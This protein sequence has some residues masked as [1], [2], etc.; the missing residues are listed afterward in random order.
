MFT[1][2][3]LNN[4]RMVM[5]MCNHAVRKP[6]LLDTEGLDSYDGLTPRLRVAGLHILRNLNKAIKNL[7]ESIGNLKKSIKFFSKFENSPAHS[8]QKSACTIFGI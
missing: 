8:S 7:K 1:R 6:N 4:K 3:L 5:T 2:I